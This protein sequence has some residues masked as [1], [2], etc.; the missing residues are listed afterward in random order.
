MKKIWVLYTGGTIGMVQGEHG[1]RPDTA[2]AG[3]ALAPFACRLHFDWHVCQ[4]LIDSSAVQPRDWAQW[5][6]L[7]EQKLPDYDVVLV[8]LGTVTKA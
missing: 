6:L 7:I 5:R 3:T 1:L 4:P 2:L 8:L